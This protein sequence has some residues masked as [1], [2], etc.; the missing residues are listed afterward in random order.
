MERFGKNGLYLVDEPEAALSPQRQLA[1]LGRLHGLVEDGCQFLI[2]THSPILMAYPDA[3][4]YGYGERGIHPVAY[5]DTE[6]YR[7][8]HDFIAN[9]ARMLAIL[10]GR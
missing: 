7:V 2:A 1:L 4:I 3:L 5:E 8:T 10:M 6:H 9:P